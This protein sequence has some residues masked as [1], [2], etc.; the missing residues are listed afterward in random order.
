MQGG[1]T[2]GRSQKSEEHTRRLCISVP[3]RIR[4]QLSCPRPPPAQDASQRWRM[5]QHWRAGGCCP[6][7]HTHSH[8]CEAHQVG[9]V[10]IQVLN[11]VQHQTGEVGHG[12]QGGVVA[13]QVPGNPVLCRGSGH[14]GG[15]EGTHVCGWLGGEE[16]GGS[17]RRQSGSWRRQ[18]G[19]GTGPLPMLYCSRQSA[20]CR[21]ATATAAKGS[22]ISSERR[23]VRCWKKD[24]PPSAMPWQAAPHDGTHRRGLSQQLPQRQALQ[25]PLRQRHACSKAVQ[26]RGEWCSCI[27]VCNTLWRITSHTHSTR[28]W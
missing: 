11:D 23:A 4:F 28:T 7:V 8:L 25:P 27:N 18:L 1:H 10:C 20:S 9:H 22:P 19:R 14:T 21:R 24:S 3:C 26:A 2:G 12:A 15:R 5:L 6:A 16:G 13:R 17:W